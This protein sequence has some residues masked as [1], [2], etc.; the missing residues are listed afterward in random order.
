MPP[1]QLFRDRL[2]ADEA[3]FFTREL[4][5]IIA[6]SIDF[7][8]PRLKT[9]ELFPTSFEVDPGARSITWHEYE[10]V[11]LAAI[12]A[13]YAKDFPTADVKGQENTS[14]VRG[15]GASYRYSLDDIRASRMANKSLDQ[16]RA[17]SAKE[18]VKRKEN[19]I[20]LFGDAAYNIP[21][22]FS[23]A[24]ITTGTVA[25]DGVAAST[26]WQ[27]KTP[28]QILRDMNDAVQG[29]LNL[30]NEVE[31]PN[32]MLLS[33]TMLGYISTLRITGINET[34]LAFFLKTNQYVNQV[35]SLPECDAAN[36]A[37]YATDIMVVYDRNP[38]KLELQ[39]P[40]DFET[41]SPQQT[42][43]EFKVPVHEKIGGVL[44]YKPLSIALY[45][46]LDT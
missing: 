2:D 1:K 22:F 27:S 17:N 23:N 40:Q 38:M 30:T 9:R 33:S 41:F 39:I 11:G 6:G 8:L 29:V 18:S 5:H 31:A 42:M 34:V 44:V 16:R 35:V 19:S 21:G 32:T 25:A 43:L 28:D 46:G 15:M 4:E 20:A 14:Q 10:P 13:N 37:L 36:N 24:N 26:E 12:I 7:E 3:I 45:D